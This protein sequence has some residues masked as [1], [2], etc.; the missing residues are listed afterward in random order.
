MILY[1]TSPFFR[2]GGPEN[3]HLTVSLINEMMKGTDVRAMVIYI[4]SWD[5][6]SSLYPS[7]PNLILGSLRDIEDIPTNVVVVP[8]IYHVLDFTKRFQIVNCQIVVWWQSFVNACMNYTVENV[9]APNVMHVFH[10]YYEYV[11]IRPYLN[12]GQKHAFLTD[13]LIDEYTSIEEGQYVNNNNNNE[14]KALVC[15]NGNRDHIT[16]Q[17]CQEH[18]IPYIEIKDMTRP[19]V[20]DVLRQC[21]IYADMGT[22]PGKDHL[23]REAAMYGCVVITNKSGS[24]AYWEDVPIL[25]K[26]TYEDELPL[27]INRIFENYQMYHDSQKYYRQQIRNEKNVA[28]KHTKKFVDMLIKSI[29]VPSYDITYV[30][31]SIY[32]QS[33]KH[34]QHILDDLKQICLHNGNGVVE[35]NCFTEHRNVQNELS[36]LLPKQMNLYSLGINAT[37]ILEI[38]FNAGHSALL[39]LLA[40]P[41]SKLVCFDICQH[42][43]VYKCFKYLQSIFNDRIDLIVGDST[44]TVPQYKTS[45]PDSTFDL[46]HIDGSHDVNMAR[47]DFMNCYDVASNLIIF[48]DTQEPLLDNLLNEFISEGLVSNVPI[49]KTITYQHRVVRKCT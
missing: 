15:F 38:G 16:R 31:T 46:I 22:H 45:K 10:S 33:I 26:V 13:F 39:F 47:K 42:P 25:Q 43:Y 40:S 41:S 23:P 48:D 49:R 3:T 9:H 44:I 24:A 30:P 32:E 5:G 20:C 29:V 19:Q 27:L 14:K 18:N 35:G 36:E 1:F 8:E 7:I 34:H 6:H 2:T 4:D 12:A 28:M 37:N 17:V 11:M 21:Q